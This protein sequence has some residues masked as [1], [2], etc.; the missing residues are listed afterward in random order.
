MKIKMAIGQRAGGK[1]KVEHISW[2]EQI[3]LL[4]V[5]ALSDE[6]AW[7]D[8]LEAVE[9]GGAVSVRRLATP[10]PV[11]HRHGEVAVKTAA[12]SNWDNEFSSAQA[13]ARE[14][15]ARLDNL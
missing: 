3:D 10:T 4:E 7:D 12:A 5:D 14:V 8:L 9:E 11:F 6:Y 15:L 1:G 13:H 2:R